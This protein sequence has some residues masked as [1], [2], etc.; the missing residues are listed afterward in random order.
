MLPT[1]NTTDAP[2]T[3]SANGSGTSATFAVPIRF[4]HRSTA[5]NPAS[6]RS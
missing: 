2:M 3:G 4:E 5:T 6:T 1:P